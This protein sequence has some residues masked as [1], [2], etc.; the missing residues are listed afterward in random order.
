MYSR[1]HKSLNPRNENPIPIQPKRRSGYFGQEKISRPDEIRT[2]NDSAHNLVIIPTAKPCNLG[3]GNM[4]M[5]VEK[6]R[7]EKE[8]VDSSLQAIS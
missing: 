3:D 2:P 1:R 4:F 7:I 5:K 6:V 8:A